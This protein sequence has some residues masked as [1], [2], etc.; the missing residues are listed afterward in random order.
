MMKG[1]ND[2]HGNIRKCINLN[3]SCLSGEDKGNGHVI[4]I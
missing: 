3:S 1:G 4:Q 2:R